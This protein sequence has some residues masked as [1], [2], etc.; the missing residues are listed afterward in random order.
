[1]FLRDHFDP[2]FPHE[3]GNVDAHRSGE[4][5][6]G[7]THAGEIDEA[8]QVF[9]GIDVQSFRVPVRP[10]SGILGDAFTDANARDQALHVGLDGLKPFFRRGFVGL[11]VQ[12][13]RRRSDEHVSVDRRAHELALRDLR[14]DRKHD[15][16]HLTGG[17]PV[18][19]VELSA[20]RHD[21]VIGLSDHGRDLVAVEGGGVDDHFRF[22]GAARRLDFLHLA[23]FGADAGD[24]RFQKEMHAVFIGVFR[25]R[26]HQNERINDAFPRDIKAALHFG[27]QVRLHFQQFRAGLVLHVVHAVFNGLVL[28]V[29]Q[30][31][32]LLAVHCGQDRADPFERN[33]EVF[34]D[35]V[36]HG[37]RSD[38]EFRLQRAGRSVVSGMNDRAV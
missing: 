1:M 17:V 13:L 16:I 26:L 30:F 19:N 31:F 5:E 32:E 9:P 10:E 6:S 29:L 11:I 14:R 36:V 34:C 2:E 22:N 33:V 12:V 3:I 8:F 27:V 25:V 7:R 28:D 37:I 23:V 18:Q 21:F 15:V 24:L 4:R 35:L 38:D 20:P